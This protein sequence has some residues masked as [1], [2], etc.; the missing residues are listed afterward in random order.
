MY[1][2]STALSVASL[3]SASVLHGTAP[4]MVVARDMLGVTGL[5]FGVYAAIGVVLSLAAWWTR[6]RHDK[7]HGR[8]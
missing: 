1:A 4:A 7:T 3:G 6:R 2:P 5:G 8:S